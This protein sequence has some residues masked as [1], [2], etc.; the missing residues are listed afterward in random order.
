[1]ELLNHFKSVTFANTMTVK[2]AKYKKTSHYACKNFVV[3]KS[4]VCMSP[5]LSH[6]QLV[7]YLLWFNFILGLNLLF[8]CFKLII[9]QY[10]NQK[11]KKRKLKPRIK[12]NHNISMCSLAVFLYVGYLFFQFLSYC[13]R[14]WYMP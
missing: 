8:F 14:S 4:S 5:L 12:L 6:F 11:Q 2:I 13:L 9:I 1:M 10:Y 3:T 7:L